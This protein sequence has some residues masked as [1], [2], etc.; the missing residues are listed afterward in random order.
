M[1]HASIS[2]SQ[3]GAML[4]WRS[5]GLKTRD[6]IRQTVIA[7]LSGVGT[8]ETRRDRSDLVLHARRRL[9]APEIAMLHPTWLEI[10]PVDI[11]GGGVP[12]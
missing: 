1:W 12:W 3:N 10:I 8:G 4:A 6:L 9:S 7:L 11:A 2:T 5:C